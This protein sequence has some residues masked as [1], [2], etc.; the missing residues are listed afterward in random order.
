MHS[1]QLLVTLLSALSIASA[2]TITSTF[3]GTTTL[4]SNSPQQTSSE[5]ADLQAY[6]KTLT[7]DPKYSSYHSILA[8]AV[9][10]ADL[11]KVEIDPN[12]FATTAV[13]YTALS[14]YDALPT[15]AKAYFSSINQAQ[16]SIIT[17]DL[18]GKAPRPTGALVGAGAAAAGVLG[19]AA[20]L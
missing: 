10:S 20:M 16:E 2:K 1:T 11:A 4:L 3:T 8:T 12:K 13:P 6:A 9:P 5:I 14:G 17:K 15:D 19:L 18:A 7:A